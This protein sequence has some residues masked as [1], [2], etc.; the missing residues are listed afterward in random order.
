MVVA[1]LGL[2]GPAAA[3][4]RS[5]PPDRI[6]SNEITYTRWAFVARIANVYAA[7][8][9]SARRI[10]KL[11]WRTEDG[12]SE[13]YLLLRAHW[14]RH[15]LEWIKLRIP[16]RPN[17]RIG[18]VQANALGRFHL[19]HQRVVI[20]RTRLRLWHPRHATDDLCVKL[21]P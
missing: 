7:P 5:H 8:R 12:Y 14:D 16:G 19:T 10:T 20:N 9:T 18:W 15:G 11:H 3:A 21:W 6:L 1:I 17:G 4:K 2:A 13:I